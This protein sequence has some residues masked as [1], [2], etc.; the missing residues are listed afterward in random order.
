MARATLCAA[1]DVQSEV[2]ALN[3]WISKWKESL[4]HFSGNLG[5]GCCVDMYDVEGPIEAVEDIP[6]E[7]LC[8]SDWAD[9]NRSAACHRER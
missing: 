8:G 4:T 2:D 7:L 9:P 5:C 6:G 1:T 3:A